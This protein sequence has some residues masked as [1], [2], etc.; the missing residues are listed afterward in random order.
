[1]SSFQ[2]YQ[3]RR[4]KWRWRLISDEQKIISVSK[5][6]LPTKEECL[7]G[8]KSVIKLADVVNIEQSQQ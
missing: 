8:V 2:I 5:I 3:D 6:S 1:M 7:L 4:E